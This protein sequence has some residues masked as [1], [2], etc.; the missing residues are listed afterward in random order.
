M[1][2]EP[3]GWKDLGKIVAGR[4]RE[5][6]RAGASGKRGKQRNTRTIYLSLVCIVGVTESLPMHLVFCSDFLGWL[7]Y[8]ASH[9]RPDDS[10]AVAASALPKAARRL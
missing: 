6:T 4:I 7:T 5:V 8:R 3:S 2:W 10:P 9:F 1:T